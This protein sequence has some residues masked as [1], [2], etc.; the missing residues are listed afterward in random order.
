MIILSFSAILTLVPII[1]II[2]LIG[3]AAGL[4]RGMDFFSFFGLSS[5]LG[6][7]QGGAAGKGFKSLGNIKT[8]ASAK[9]LTNT[10]KAATKGIPKYFSEQKAKKQKLAARMYEMTQR[11]SNTGE[12]AKTP[13]I[14]EKQAS[15]GKTGSTAV[16]AAPAGLSASG[17]VLMSIGGATF[18]LAEKTKKLEEDKRKQFEKQASNKIDALNAE[19]KR[20]EEQR[21]KIETKMSEKKA[22]KKEQAKSKKTVF[23]LSGF[24]YESVKGQNRTVN[25]SMPLIGLLSKKSKSD[26]L[27]E[28]IEKIES[29]QNDI[30]YKI[31]LQRLKEFKK[32]NPEAYKSIQAYI[33]NSERTVHDVALGSYFRVGNQTVP[34]RVWGFITG[35]HHTMAQNIPN[36][37]ISPEQYL[38]TPRIEEKLAERGVSKESIEY[39]RTQ[40]HKINLEAIRAE[41][42]SASGFNKD[43]GLQNEPKVMPA[44]ALNTISAA[45]QR[46]EGYL[47]I[48]S[49]LLFKNSMKDN[50]ITLS[51]EDASSLID[52]INKK[53]SAKEAEILSKNNIALNDEIKQKIS[54]AYKESR[55][56]AALIVKETNAKATSEFANRVNENIHE[57]FQE[58]HTELFKSNLISNLKNDDPSLLAA[59]SQKIN[60]YSPSAPSDLANAM[61]MESL[62]QKIG[63]K[64]VT[65]EAYDYLKQEA[66]KTDPSLAHSLDGIKISSNGMSLSTVRNALADSNDTVNEKYLR[67]AVDFA[68]AE[69]THLMS[70][71]SHLKDI[72]NEYA[73]I[74]ESKKKT[75]FEDT[76]LGRHLQQILEKEK[77]QRKQESEAEEQREIN[78]EK[79]AEEREKQKKIDENK[80]K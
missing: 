39:F 78:R 80:D 71:K 41:L 67:N 35:Q 13:S 57:H 48:A 63:S 30:D 10:R 66:I 64:P 5:L 25:V 61:V 72:A 43:T 52:A 15:K 24:G 29:K 51:N 33:K 77:A 40:A 50:N 56:E 8:S 69:T 59:V 2:I 76:I 18:G 12:A 37:N 31:N 32:S 62:K 45:K 74:S 46:N 75:A 23:H 22:E 73:S 4:S 70:N 55:R 42:R 58:M 36:N 47:D 53:N 11:F 65:Q 54:D 21:K 26:L 38:K 28:K 79:A 7:S 60:N 34:Q 14:L 68:T 6:F 9:A 17:F 49:A 19:K 20:L 1:V 27:Q 16:A 3:A 44:S